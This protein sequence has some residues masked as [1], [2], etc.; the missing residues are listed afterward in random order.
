M[1]SKDR[2]EHDQKKNND[3]C[4]LE[5]I[6]WAMDA[7]RQYREERALAARDPLTGQDDTDE[8]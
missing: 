8:D 2:G 5:W 4:R 7:A 6:A 1:D 3:I